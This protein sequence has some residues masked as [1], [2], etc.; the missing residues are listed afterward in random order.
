MPNSVS[1]N[2]SSTTGPWQG[3]LTYLSGRTALKT[4]PMLFLPLRTILP[5]LPQWLH[6]LPSVLTW[7]HLFGLPSGPSV[8]S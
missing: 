6:Y 7:G 4:V 3:P 5:R 2:L 8:L 1:S